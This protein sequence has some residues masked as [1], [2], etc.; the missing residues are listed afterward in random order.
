MTTCARCLRSLSAE[1]PVRLPDTREYCAA[2]CQ[3]MATDAF[4]MET[5][6]PFVKWIEK[7]PRLVMR[8]QPLEMSVRRMGFLFPVFAAVIGLLMVAF[9]TLLYIRRG[10]NP[11]Y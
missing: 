4:E 1:N 7:H 10:L 8:Y 5:G 11:I 9:G 6:E 2:C 3:N